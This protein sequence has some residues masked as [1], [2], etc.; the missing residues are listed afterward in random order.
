MSSDAD[1]PKESTTV[2]VLRSQIVKQAEENVYLRGLLSRAKEAMIHFTPAAEGQSALIKEI[3]RAML[4]P[5]LK[6]LREE[7]SS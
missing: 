4:P 5:H 7:E 1:S 6:D 3:E 2:E